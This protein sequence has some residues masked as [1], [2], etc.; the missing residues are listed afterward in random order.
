[1]VV[2]YWCKFI[3]FIVRKEGKLTQLEKYKKNVLF[4]INPPPVKTKPRVNISFDRN[5]IE[6][7]Y[8]IV[9]IHFSKPC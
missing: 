1:L 9:V 6:E 4:V 3:Q 2:G 8:S 5:I 7:N